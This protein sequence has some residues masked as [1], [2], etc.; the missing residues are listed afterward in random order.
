[1]INVGHRYTKPV[2]IFKQ[3]LS[4]YEKGILSGL[5][6]KLKMKLTLRIKT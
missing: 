3:I 5:G 2:R 1:M 4:L 6:E